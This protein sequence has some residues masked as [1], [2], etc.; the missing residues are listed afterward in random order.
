MKIAV[1]PHLPIIA[2]GYNG[3]HEF[4]KLSLPDL[5]SGVTLYVPE[6]WDDFLAECPGIAQDYELFSLLLTL[7]VVKIQSAKKADYIKL[8]PDILADSEKHVR[9]I[10]K[11]QL[12]A[13]YLIDD[14]KRIYAGIPKAGTDFI[15]S[16]DNH[17]VKIINFSPD[18]NLSLKELIYSYAPKLNQ[19]KHNQKRRIAGNKEISSF[20]AYDRLNEDYARLLLRQAY[21]EYPGEIDERTYLYTYDA[22]CKTFVEFRP[23]RNNEY[24]GMDI[25]RKEALAKCPRI[26][27]LYH[28]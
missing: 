12:F 3:N 10:A 4:D 7:P 16:A 17:E 15:V 11:Q 6:E 5:P 19:L 2:A 21:E 20:S 26:V 24:H 25:S 27:E 13:I 8:N 28:K 1:A 14:A 23:D 18:S 9:D 22:K